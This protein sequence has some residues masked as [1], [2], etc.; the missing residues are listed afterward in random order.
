MQWSLPHQSR[1]V[2]F[3]VL[4]RLFLFLEGRWSINLWRDTRGGIISLEYTVLAAVLVA[5]LVP[6]ATSVRDSIRDGLASI[7][8]TVQRLDRTD[9]PQ[10][11]HNPTCLVTCRTL[12]SEQE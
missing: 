6:A 10:V 7:A 2:P 5:G 8:T 11:T 4:T 12:W 3:G 9:P 1:S